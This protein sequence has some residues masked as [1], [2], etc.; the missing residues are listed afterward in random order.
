MKHG[1]SNVE[2]DHQVRIGTPGKLQRGVLIFATMFFVVVQSSL[3]QE[4]NR[5][6]LKDFGLTEAPRKANESEITIFREFSK[7]SATFYISNKTDRLLCVSAYVM[8][9]STAYDPHRFLL[10]PYQQQVLAGRYQVPARA[11]GSDPSWTADIRVM[12]SS[13]PFMSE[14]PSI[15]EIRGWSREER[16]RT[17][18][19]CRESVPFPS[20]GA[21]WQ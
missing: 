17:E 20:Q 9:D 19:R 14:R 2:N 4:L 3:A 18:T 6:T 10:E 7:S 1:A 5:F 13:V 8:G 11:F 12:I 16:V 15:G 21:V